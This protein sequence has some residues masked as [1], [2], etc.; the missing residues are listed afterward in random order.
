MNPCTRESKARSGRSIRLL[1]AKLI[2]DHGMFSSNE[3]QQEAA[4]RQDSWGVFGNAQ[5]FRKLDADSCAG[6]TSSRPPVP[7]TSVHFPFYV[8]CLLCC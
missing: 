4:D 8:M 6:F 5:D 3:S 7:L 1:S 2:S